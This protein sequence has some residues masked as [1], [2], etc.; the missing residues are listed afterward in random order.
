VQ[1]ITTTTNSDDSFTDYYSSSPPQPPIP[2]HTKKR[3]VLIVDNEPDIL[4]ICT[5]ALSKKF[6][7]DSF[8]NPAEAFEHFNNNSSDYDLVLTDVRMPIM[9]GFKLAKQIHNIRQDIPMTAFDTIDL[10]YKD[11]FP[12]AASREFIS[13]PVSMGKLEQ[14]IC[15]HIKM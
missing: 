8:S 9:S 11:V 10:E 1:L 13:K 12:S 7:I 14:L 15:S 4:V 5:K 3:K 6:N 2:P